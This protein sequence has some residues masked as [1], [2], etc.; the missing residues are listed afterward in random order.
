MLGSL[1]L[2]PHE[3]ADVEID[4]GGSDV[5]FMTKRKEASPLPG[6]RVGRLRGR[7]GNPARSSDLPRR[8]G[9]RHDLRMRME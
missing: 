1:S 3:A 2:F 6:R 7:I 8:R 4:G 5:Q 9:R